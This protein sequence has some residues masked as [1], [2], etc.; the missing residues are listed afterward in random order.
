MPARNYELYFVNALKHDSVYLKE[1]KIILGIC[2]QLP[3]LWK[4]PFLCAYIS[5]D[6]SFLVSCSPEALTNFF[7]IKLSCTAYSFRA[8]S[9]FQ[10]I[11][12]GNFNLNAL[13]LFVIDGLE[14]S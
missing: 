10:L 5:W 7:F 12:F 6:T 1:K 2:S 8:D 4:P 14:R 11:G 13:L 9:F 3:P